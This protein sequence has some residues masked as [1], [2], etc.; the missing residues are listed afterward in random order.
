M[1]FSGLLHSR[2]YY[3]NFA[4]ARRR[5]CERERLKIA[6]LRKILERLKMNL[7][8]TATGRTDAS[9]DSKVLKP[10]MFLSRGCA[11]SSISLVMLVLGLFQ[12]R[13]GL[14]LLLWVVVFLL[15]LRLFWGLLFVRLC[16][17]LCRRFRRFRGRTIGRIIVR[18][19]VRI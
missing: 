18:S 14:G 17:F 9:L 7:M 10:F 12:M 11:F 19:W 13:I 1:L 6:L 4:R 2:F 5:V 3:L 15:V 8:K 16:S